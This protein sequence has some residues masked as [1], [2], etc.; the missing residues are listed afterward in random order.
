MFIANVDTNEKPESHWVA[1]YF[2]KDREGEFFDSYG[3][4]PINFAGTFTRFLNNYS[5]KWNLNSMTLQSMKRKACGHYCLYY[6]LFRR[7][8]V[9]L[10]TIVHR[11]SNNKLRN[12]FLVKRFIEKRFPQSLKKYHTHENKQGSKAQHKVQ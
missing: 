1:F 3:L 6:A 5:K 12:D 11:F 10:S 4:T 8:N 2:T 9:S 7:R